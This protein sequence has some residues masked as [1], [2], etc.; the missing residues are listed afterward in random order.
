MI[1]RIDS[2]EGETFSKRLE[3]LQK[4]IENLKK[5]E[6][7]DI[8]LNIGT[9]PEK[10]VPSSA[11]EKVY[12]KVS[13]VVLAKVFSELGFYSKPI[14]AR[15]NT[16]DVTIESKHFNYSVM[17]DCKCFR[18]TRTAK[19]QKDFKV[20]SLKSW[21]KGF[22]Y[23]LLVVPEYHVYRSSS[24]F[25]QASLFNVQIIYWETLYFLLKEGV[26]E[27][28]Q[29]NFE[30]LFNFNSGETNTQAILKGF[31][32][33]EIDT[34]ELVSSYNHRSEIEKQELYFQINEIEKLSKE[35]L[36]T[37]LISELGLENKIERINKQQE[38][39]GG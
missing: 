29:F 10:Y 17:S 23:S 2:E 7:L 25:K 21:S 13:E 8:V 27:S 20:A 36:M 3:S 26:S 30:S 19:N 9:I 1:K 28:V 4:Y 38:N 33:K 14:N 16:G 18:Q 35:E 12:S 22:D 39:W 5:E 6:L 31:L 24:I 15:Q 32:H 37:R 34:S 11:N